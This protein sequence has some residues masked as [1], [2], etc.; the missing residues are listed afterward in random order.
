MRI[1]NHP[2]VKRYAAYYA[3]TAHRPWL[4]EVLHC[5]QFYADYILDQ[6][7]MPRGTDLPAGDRI[8]LREHGDVAGGAVGLWQLIPRTAQ[9]NGLNTDGAVDERHDF[10]KA[11]EAALNIL[12]VRTPVEK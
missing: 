9:L 3:S 7:G 10:W 5:V 12:Q 8:E 1:P 11:T 6:R 2:R 4:R